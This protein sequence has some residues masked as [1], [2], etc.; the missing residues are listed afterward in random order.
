MSSKQ[1]ASPSIPEEIRRYYDLGL[2]ADRL[3][4]AEGELEFV[5]TKEIITRYLPSP[6]AVILDV[7]GGPGTYACWLARKGFEMHLVDPVPLHTEQ[8]KLASQDQPE[9]PIRSITLGDA[10]DL[11][12][13]DNSTDA[14][15]LLGPLYH[16]TQRADRMEA[17]REAYRVLKPD[18]LLVAVGISR[19]ASTLAGL[20]DGYFA[21]AEIVPM[22]KRVLTDG[23]HRNPTGKP[24]YFTTAYLHHPS[25]LEAEVRGAGFEVENILAVEGAAVFLQD[26]EEQ[27]ARPKQRERILQ[28][29]RWLEAEPSVI[30]VT[31][32][33]AAIGVKKD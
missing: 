12:F 24:V 14:A 21:E 9:F 28:A 18:G 6:P 1:D 30:G 3:K 7:G 33:I 15:F 10:R 29:V 32:H 5:R 31:G 25:E 27:W 22:I 23:Q 8:A 11:H 16:L 2:E 20:I 17:L 26:L 19:F 4:T 13:N